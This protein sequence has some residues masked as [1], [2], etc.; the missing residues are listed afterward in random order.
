MQGLT[1]N[2]K[3]SHEI[4]IDEYEDNFKKSNLGEE[5]GPLP[6]IERTTCKIFS[7]CIQ[8]FCDHFE[9]VHRIIITEYEGIFK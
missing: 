3:R 7:S 2:M 8:D 5:P 1:A 9:R 6:T 4:T